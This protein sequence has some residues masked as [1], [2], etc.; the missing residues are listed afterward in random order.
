MRAAVDALALL[1]TLGACVPINDAER[2]RL[3]DPDGDGVS[4][5]TYCDN[6][7]PTIVTKTKYR[8]VDGDGF[9][10]ESTAEWGCSADPGW[11]MQP[12]DC[13]D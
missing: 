8:D 5:Y 3:F 7:D 2:E 11:S 9:G 1:H 13:D 12:G 10:D 4:P 6:Q